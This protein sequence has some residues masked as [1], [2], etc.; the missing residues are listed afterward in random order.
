MRL[1]K[2][3]VIVSTTFGDHLEVRARFGRL[4][5]TALRAA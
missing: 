2:M 1:G 4:A 5:S 3:I